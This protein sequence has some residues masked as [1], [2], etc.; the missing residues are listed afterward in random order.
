[1]IRFRSMGVLC[2]VAGLTVGCG[3]EY[4][5]GEVEGEKVPIEK[6]FTEEQ[7]LIG[8]TAASSPLSVGSISGCTATLVDPRFVLTAAHC[9]NG[10][11]PQWNQFD[12]ANSSASATIDYGYWL[13]NPYPSQ[14][15]YEHDVALLRLD[16]PALAATPTSIAPALPAE[17]TA[18]TKYGF[19]CQ[20]RSTGGGGGYFQQ[21]S[22]YWPDS[23]VNCP[24]DSGGPVICD[25][26]VAAVN[27]GYGDGDIHGHAWQSIPMIVAA[28]LVGETTVSNTPQ[29]TFAAWAATSGVKALAGD[30]DNDGRT[31]LAL[32]GG[33]GWASLPVAFNR[34]GSPVTW[35][36]RN[37][38][39]GAFATWANQARGAVVGDF[40]GDGRDDIALY[41][42]PGW[43]TIPM[44]F[45]LGDGSFRITNL[46]QQDAFAA[47][48]NDPS[49]KVVAGD[50]DVD[51]DADLMVTGVPGWTSLPVG[52]SLRDGTFTPLNHQVGGFADWAATS[53]R[54]LAGDFNGDGAADIAL[55]GN[56]GWA[57]IPVAY[58]R[59]NGSFD[60]QNHGIAWFPVW[61]AD[62]GVKLTVG[63]FDGDGDSDIAATGHAGWKTV[64]FAFSSRAGFET[65]NL[66]NATFAGWAAEARALLSGDLDQDGRDDLTLTGASGWTTI[67]VALT[68]PGLD[69]ARLGAVR[70][71][72]WDASDPQQSSRYVE[73]HY[74]TSNT[75]SPVSVALVRGP[76]DT[77][78]TLVRV[79]DTTNWSVVSQNDDDPALY[80]DARLTFTPVRG[81]T[82]VVRATTYATGA[83][84]DYQLAVAPSVLAPGESYNGQLELTDG[85]HPTRTA[86]LFDGV[87]LMPTSTRSVTVNLQ[88]TVF[89][90]Y[91]EAID[92][93]TGSVIGV[94]DDCSGTLNSCLTLSVSDRRPV[95]LRVS[96][97]YRYGTGGYTL[98]V[99]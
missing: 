33:A 93:T 85:V 68:R 87:V 96:S 89:D 92:A 18:C 79:I 43:T 46:S 24:G 17:G 50:V 62:V 4:A 10:T 98:T 2:T 20:D 31:D 7:A 53:A 80:R 38:G 69:P 25:G 41:G 27:S 59:L 84:G 91:L 72:S 28:R 16:R 77:V 95:I 73:D 39:V 26:T 44:A 67:P 15:G 11:G 75:A 74:F 37:A 32:A 90:A 40:D 63:D 83:T 19:G 71:G 21:V 6:L 14:S 22:F 56:P 8:G 94:N 55:V 60:V 29:G 54:A 88:S 52:L 30:F 49:A 5:S 58:S 3:A 81:R 64:A 78:D 45:S 51:G 23:D 70:T 34:A 76:S 9:I 97:Y 42:G 13:W 65:G 12:Y 35:D 82:Y 86:R 1:M 66:T 36:I 57:S 47:W 61:A 48:V 99:N